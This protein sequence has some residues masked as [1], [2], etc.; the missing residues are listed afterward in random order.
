MW[1]LCAFACAALEYVELAS[2][3][4]SAGEVIGRAYPDMHSALEE[5]QKTG[6]DLLINLPV[7]QAR[8]LDIETPPRRPAF[9]GEAYFD[10]LRRGL[11]A[12]G[13]RGL[14]PAP[15]GKGQVLVE[16]WPG[17]AGAAEAD[18]DSE[19]LLRPVA[20]IEHLGAGEYNAVFGVGL[21]AVIVWTDGEK[22]GALTPVELA[23]RFES[24]EAV[25]KI[26]ED[27]ARACEGGMEGAR[28]F[29]GSYARSRTSTRAF[30]LAGLVACG[31]L[32]AAH[33]ARRGRGG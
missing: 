7:L 4:A 3:V 5:A 2:D 17:S 11:A 6:C 10:L 19:E 27:F 32:L 31:I 15:P 33:L 12:T 26:E 16:P 23:F 25:P 22:R 1:G 9:L 30:A 13:R 8:G 18:L 20:R 24:G 21:V 28:R 14:R 29:C